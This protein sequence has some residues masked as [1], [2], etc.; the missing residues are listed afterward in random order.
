LP[1]LDEELAQLKVAAGRG[2][3]AHAADSEPN[4]AHDLPDA[5]PLNMPCGLSLC[6]DYLI[7][8]D[9]AHSRP[10]GWRL[11]E[12]S[13]HTAARG[14]AGEPHFRAKGDNRWRA[15]KR[16][17]LGWPY[18]VAACQGLAASADTGNN[19]VLLWEAAR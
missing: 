9:T 16:G 14:L 11:T 4:G 5:R 7:A 1:K 8:A 10:V 13:R 18:G 15:A 6:G 12:P 3:R 19:R 17:S 2:G